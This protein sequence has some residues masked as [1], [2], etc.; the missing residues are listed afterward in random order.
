MADEINEVLS[1]SK[2]VNSDPDKNITYYR[3]GFHLRIFANLLDILIFIFLFFCLF[4]GTRE[5]VN[6]TPQYKAKSQQLTD[7]R[8]NSGL[9]AR[10]ENGVLRDII[11]VLNDDDAQSAKSRK[12]KS[13]KAID[14]FMTYLKEVGSEE[15]YNIIVSDYKDYRL[16]ED[17]KIEDFAMFILDGENVV[18]NPALVEDIG[19]IESPV[20]KTYYEKAYQPYIDNRL[21]AYLV[22]SIPHYKAIIQY[23]T[24]LLI[25][26]E[27]FMNYCI[28]GLIVYLLPL[29]IFRRG[30]KTFGKAIYGI[31]LVDKNCLS[32]KVGRTLAR[33]AIFYFAELILSLFTFGLPLLIS[34]SL[35]AFSKKRQG[36]PDYMLGLQEVDAKRTKIYLS[37]QEVELEKVETHKKPINFTTKN[38]D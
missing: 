20:F 9:Y 1:D 23:Q 4:L 30:R 34:F 31:G 15:D 37:I 2:V 32:P 26:L 17:M 38:F 12:V 6:H 36:F 24:N 8:L 13:S 25:W 29:F 18:E 3:P 5:I 10:D 22:T 35:M 27:I 14:T 19:N 16:A 7:I 21:Q 11:S 28:T 33:F